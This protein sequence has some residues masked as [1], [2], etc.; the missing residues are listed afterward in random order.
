MKKYSFIIVLSAL[1][2]SSCG[3]YYKIL[4]ST[5][6][7][8]KWE[9]AKKYYAAKKYAY[10]GTILGELVTVFKGTDK[11]EECMY[12]LAQSYF[13]AKDYTT[14]GQYFQQYYTTYPKGEYTELSR[15][16]CAYGYFLDSPDYRLDQTDTHKGI[17]EFQMFLEYFP[18]SEKVS[19]A[20]D[21]LAQMQD[22]LV[23]KDY[24]SAQLYYNLG[25]YIDN[26]YLAAV[27]TAQ[28]AL[29]EYPNTTLRE[30]L[31]ILI[32]RSRYQEA[33]HSVASKQGDR[34]RMVIDECYNYRNE[35][36]EGKYM[37]EALRYY[38]VAQ[39][40][41]G[42]DAETIDANDPLV[43]GGKAKKGKEK[44]NQIK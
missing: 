17:R 4:K 10:S 22:K 33:Y 23:L 21:M 18:R 7:E 35:F 30:D 26:N 29:R 42:S 38:D 8:V 13:G 31:T 12:L 41:T 39:R 20:Q 14:S 37:K 44:G 28:N 6:Y 24:K 34:Y 40:F 2:F 27:V 5:D 43:V 16:Y 25:N 15:F 9:A 11:A 32:L 36:P 19:E 1:L 3:D